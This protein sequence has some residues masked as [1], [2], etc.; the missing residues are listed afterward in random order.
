MSYL[1]GK[2]QT[3]QVTELKDQQKASCFKNF[4]ACKSIWAIPIKILESKPVNILSVKYKRHVHIDLIGICKE[5]CFLL[6]IL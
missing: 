6:G 2:T 3:D 5:F 4:V 1:R